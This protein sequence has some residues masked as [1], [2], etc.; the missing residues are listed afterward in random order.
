MRTVRR[1]KTDPETAENDDLSAL[2]VIRFLILLDLQGNSTSW[3]L[4]YEGKSTND[5]IWDKRT[6][7][8]INTCV[9][10]K[11][12]N[13]LLDGLSGPPDPV[14]VSE[15]RYVSVS[16]CVPHFCP[17][18]GF[19]WLDTTTGIGLGAVFG[20]DDS[21]TL[22]IG[23]NGMPATQVPAAARAGL[24]D[25]LTENEL[26]PAKVEFIGSQ[27][28]WQSLDA[29]GFKPR[30]KYQPAAG[31]PGFDCG[32]ASGVIESTIC[33]DASLSSLDLAMFKLVESIRRGHA[34][35][36]ARTELL[37]MQRAWTRQRDAECVSAPAIKTCLESKY[38]EQTDK[39]GNWLPKH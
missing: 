4:S 21:R 36:A 11:L 14:I 25:W 38:R 16:A 23:S 26:Q 13:D 12:S 15:H 32:Q 5:F 6:A 7:S 1:T 22:K 39:L 35:L 28:N 20:G 34:T 27:G 30:A 10:A 19:F 2:L 3:M 37:E 8:L 31:G 33:G 17:T 18:K 9:P 29:S 24:I